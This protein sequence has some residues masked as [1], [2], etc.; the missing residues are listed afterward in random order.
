MRPRHWIPGLIVGVLGVGGA[1]LFAPRVAKTS[2]VGTATVQSAPAPAPPPVSSFDSAWCGNGVEALPSDVCYINGR[3]SSERNT[4]VIWLHGVIGKNTNWSQDHVKM[5]TRMAKSTNIEM[6]F[7]KGI[8]GAQVYGWP[9]TAEDQAE[10]EGA[11]IDQWMT[12]KQ[13]LEQREG[14]KFD[15]V[16]IFGFS[17]GAYFASSL[18]MR[19][20]VDVDGYAVLCGGQPAPPAQA[21]G[22]VAPVFVGVCAEDETTASHSRSYGGSLAAA[23]IPRMVDEENVSHD[24]SP[25][26]FTK[27][28]AYLRK[29]KGAR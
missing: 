1:V 21:P 19:G 8:L 10:H 6:L 3:G 23:N 5:L 22:H 29:Q 16:F 15:D 7:P 17:S 13:L 25:E 14:K 9:G 24:V 11:L 26:H 27:A 4:L 2:E 18:A 12:A 28:L 20:R